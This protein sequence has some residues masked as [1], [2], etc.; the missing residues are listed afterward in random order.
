MATYSRVALSGSTNGKGIK[1]V[2][3]A[4]PGTTIH[5]AHATAQD[6]YWL[7]AWNSKTSAQLLT[8][9]IG[10]TTDPDNIMEIQL[11]A[12][13][14]GIIPIVQG[15][16]CLTGSV[17]VDAFAATANEVIIFGYVNRIT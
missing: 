15:S 3:N 7:W 11:P 9:E 12:N 16:L 17:N 1:V 4:T 6:E 13:T 5:D 8:L 14:E 10:G 2:A